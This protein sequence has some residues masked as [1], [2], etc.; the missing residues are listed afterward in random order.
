MTEYGGPGLREKVIAIICEEWPN[1]NNE[2]A[3]AT[4]YE[5]L[6]SDGTEISEEALRNILLQ[7]A[8]HGDI[9]LVIASTPPPSPGITI[10]GVGSELCT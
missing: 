6:T 5:R 4:I 3:S 8:D 9:R 10:G 1:P 2:L 7:L